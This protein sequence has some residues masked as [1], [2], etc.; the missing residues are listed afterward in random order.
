MPVFAEPE[1]ETSPWEITGA[2]GLS[3]SDGNSDRLATHL[4]L[5]A[6]RVTPENELFLNADYFYAEDDR[7]ATTDNLRLGAQFNHLV[8]ERR[9]FGFSAQFLT[10]PI[11]DLDHRID[12]STLL[13]WYALKEDRQSLAFEMGPGYT[14][15]TQA[16]SNSDFLNL[17]LAER[18]E[19]RLGDASKLWQSLAFVPEAADFDNHLLTAELGIESRITD[20]WNLR[21]FVRYQRDHSPAPG[22]E[23]ND[24]S[25]MLGVGYSLG[26]FPDPEKSAR[27]TLKPAR[28]TPTATPTGWTRSASLGTA[29]A[30]G[31]SDSRSLTST[32]ETAYHAATHEFFAGAEYLYGEDDGDTSQHQF[33]ADARLRRLFGSRRFLGAG[34]ELFHDDLADL[35]YRFTP[36]AT[37]GTYLVK[38]DAVSLSLEAGPGYTFE[39][40]GGQRSDYLSLV[41]AERFAF[42]IAPR[43]TFKQSLVWE[44]EA[45][46]LDNHTLTAAANLD[47]DLTES[48]ALRIGLTYLFD[49]TPA[50]GRAHHDT[51][52]TSG[53]A[54]KF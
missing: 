5:L 20:H 50:T 28:K 48:L 53:I 21:T 32:F 1:S 49:P 22:R 37:A 52:L 40:A 7:I 54:V 25:L 35:S 6:T 14:W 31:N 2:A 11:A 46:E 33:H 10:D 19:R 16:G 15:E 47:T 36:S 39:K 8:Q 23:E 13:G 51:T 41:A 43:L 26:G 45:A 24:L 30:S 29:L 4:Q 34:V 27:K 18:Y 17:R 44:A 12:I 9:Y 38:N 3:Y 42:V